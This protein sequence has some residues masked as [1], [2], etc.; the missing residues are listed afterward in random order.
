MKTSGLL[1]GK[2]VE[3]EAGENRVCVV[4]SFQDGPGDPQLLVVTPLCSPLP[5][6]TSGGLCDQ[7]NVAEVVVCH[8]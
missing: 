5:L 2:T 3:A 6:G 4:A 1:S 7:Q 8:F